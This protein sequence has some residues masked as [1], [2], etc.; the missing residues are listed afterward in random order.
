MNAR[1]SPPIFSHHASDQATEL[2]VDG[3]ASLPAGDASPVS[4]RRASVPGDDGGGLNDRQYFA[5]IWPQITQR[6]PEE[7]IDF[8]QMRPATAVSQGGELLSEGEILEHQ[9]STRQT[10]SARGAE[11]ELQQEEHRGTMRSPRQ[12]WQALEGAP[13]GAGFLRDLGPDRVLARHR[14]PSL[15]LNACRDFPAVECAPRRCA[16]TSRYVGA[17]E[18]LEVAKELAVG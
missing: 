15:P 12:R 7:A 17:I 18:L 9:R 4:A 16:A 1:R 3:R 5:P 10:Q 11:E 2:R 14:R 13:N 6:N 8:A